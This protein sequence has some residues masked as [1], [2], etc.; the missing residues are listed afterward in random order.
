MNHPITS[1]TFSFLKDLAENNNREWF[2]EN[3]DLY[4]K[5][6][7]NVLVFLDKLIEDMS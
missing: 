6:Q 2:N 4:L 1:K 3:K 7:E 5:A